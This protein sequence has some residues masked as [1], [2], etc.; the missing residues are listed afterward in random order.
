MAN[1]RSRPFG[2]DE[3]V[4]AIHESAIE[5][6]A[7]RGPREVTVREIAARARVNHALVHRHFGT[8]DE[9]IRTVLTAQ[10]SAI[11][12]AAKNRRGTAAMLTLLEEHRAYFR[13]LAR[14]VL[15]SPALLAGSPPPAA[16]AFLRLVGDPGADTANAAAAAGALALGWL[17]FGEHLAA[18]LGVAGP[19]SL[20]D[21][22][23]AAIDSITTGR[24]EA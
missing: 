7:E 1:R 5:L 11:A 22:V 10:S 13:A 20:R 21:G 19:Q 12:A 18:A 14:A 23:V 8:K 4:P 16:T 24:R 6:L 3:V 9:L 17:V 2:R 15:D